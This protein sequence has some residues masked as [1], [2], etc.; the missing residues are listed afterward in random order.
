MI[1]NE[2][3]PTN[4]RFSVTGTAGILSFISMMIGMVI[5]SV[6]VGIFE[7]V[8]VFC[9]VFAIPCVVIGT[10]IILITAKETKGID[11]NAIE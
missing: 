7:N 2:S 3:A 1:I 8:A 4:I 10:V 5:S 9:A 11:L 6:C